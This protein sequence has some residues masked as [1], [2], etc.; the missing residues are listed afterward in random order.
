MITL[1]SKQNV[2]D[3]Q[4]QQLSG[5]K[6]IQSLNSYKSASLQQQKQMS[7]IIS[8]NSAGTSENSTPKL[9]MPGGQTGLFQG[10]QVSGCTINIGFPLQQILL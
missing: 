7:R 4:I 8:G 1:L 10:A 3:T 2:P 9:K 6:N 5:H